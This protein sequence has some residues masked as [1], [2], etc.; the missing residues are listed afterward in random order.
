LIPKAKTTKAKNKPEIDIRN[1]LE[2]FFTEKKL[3]TK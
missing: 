2:N 3:S 1:Q